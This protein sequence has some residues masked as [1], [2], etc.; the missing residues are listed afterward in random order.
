MKE[1][2]LVQEEALSKIHATQQKIKEETEADKQRKCSKDEK[3]VSI[4]ESE[5]LQKQGFVVVA[6]FEKDGLFVH[7]LKKEA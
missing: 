4:S 1:K 6:I 7:K 3:I 5:N 2:D